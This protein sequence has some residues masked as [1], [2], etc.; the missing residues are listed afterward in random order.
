MSTN[1]DERIEFYWKD[2]SVHMNLQTKMAEVLT[3]EKTVH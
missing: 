2:E 1:N 3:R